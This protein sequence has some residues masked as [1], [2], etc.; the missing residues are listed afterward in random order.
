MVEACKRL[1][2][3]YLQSWEEADDLLGLLLDHSK[4]YMTYR[5]G[6][7]ER[8]WMFLERAWARGDTRA[9]ASRWS[10]TARAA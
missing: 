10:P 2:T 5:D 9:R 3:K 6:Y 7:I 4:A 8:E 1:L